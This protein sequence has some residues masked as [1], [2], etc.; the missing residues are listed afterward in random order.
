M[1]SKNRT[2]VESAKLIAAFFHE[3]G[4]LPSQ[5]VPPSGEQRRLADAL[6]RFRKLRAQGTLPAAVAVILGQAHPDWTA[7]P[8]LS[9]PQPYGTGPVEKADEIWRGR[10]EEFAAWVAHHGR[11]PARYAEDPQ[12]RFLSRWL[13]GQRYDSGRGR[14]P[15]RAATLDEQIPEW[16]TKKAP[17]KAKLA[18]PLLVLRH[19][20]RTNPQ[21]EKSLPVVDAAAPD[22][23]DG[24][25]VAAERHW[26]KR[27]TEL[28]HWVRTNGRFPHSS[29]GDRYE[30]SLG[31]W[32]N[33]Q[34][35]HER[36]NEYP[37]RTKELDKRLPGWEQSPR[38]R[39]LWG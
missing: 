14:F 30:R 2:A 38:P 32:L 26:E 20:N 12:E 15:D 33:R 37:H 1:T 23:L 9:K 18:N 39:K 3:H 29:A 10:V 24:I 7:R 19:G 16:R 13:A 6:N 36:K 35:A 31:G 28:V 8:D 25:A 27:A 22:R 34:R 5:N 11:F 21:P 4:Y 17:T